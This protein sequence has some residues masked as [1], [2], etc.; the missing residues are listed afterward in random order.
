M[1][2]NPH[3][4]QAAAELGDNHLMNDPHTI[5]FDR[6][7]IDAMDKRY[8][9]ALVN[10]LSGFKGANMLGTADSQGHTNLALIS[11][12]IHVGSA[13]PLLGH[14]MRPHTVPRHTLE[15]ILSTGEYTLNAVS[16]ALVE[17][18]HA[19]SARFPREVSEFNAAGLDAAYG[20]KLRAPYVAESPLQVGLRLVEH[21]TLASNGCV[22][23]IGEIVEL[24][25]SRDVRAED[26]HLDLAQLGI[27][28]ISGLDEYLVPH[29]LGRQPYAKAPSS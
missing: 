2:R 16:Q 23:V 22:M 9:A 17:R 27:V 26:G 12:A 13:P 15:N 6:A 24:R 20:T 18:A 11:S 1:R 10:S 25:L 29:T 3:G 7:D 14:L 28:A 8:R 21:H 19:S 5:N 4:C